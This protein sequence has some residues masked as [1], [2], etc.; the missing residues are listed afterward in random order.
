VCVEADWFWTTIVTGF[1]EP[2]LPE[3][4]AQNRTVLR[5][6]V[7]AARTLE[8]GGYD[9]VVD[10]IVGPWMLDVVADA[11]EDCEHVDYVV[12]RPSLATCLSRAGQRPPAERVPG[13]P[14]LNDSGPIRHMWHQFAALG[15]YDH[16]VIDTSDLSETETVRVVQEAR[17]DGR[18]RMELPA[19][20]QARE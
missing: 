10:G 17:T 16:H 4:D 8:S 3:A 19:G 6:A 14:P 5:S 20:E 7:R 12:L 1:V 18:L 15:R 13:H 11:M 2:W 9:T